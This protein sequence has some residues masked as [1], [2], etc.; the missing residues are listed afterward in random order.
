MGAQHCHLFG[1]AIGGIQMQPA[2]RHGE[3]DE[4]DAGLIDTGQRMQ[5]RLM[6]VHGVQL[7]QHGFIALRFFQQ[8]LNPAAGQTHGGAAFRCHA[9]IEHVFQICAQRGFLALAHGGRRST[10]RLQPGQ[11]VMN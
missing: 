1:A 7:H 8:Q 5:C 11:L 2:V 6:P 10:L 3:R 9:G 4:P